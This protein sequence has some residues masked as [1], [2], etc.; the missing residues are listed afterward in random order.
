MSKHCNCKT[1][2]LCITVK[3]EALKITGPKDY[4]LFGRSVTKSRVLE[5]FQRFSS[6]SSKSLSTK[7]V[8]SKKKVAYMSDLKT[9]LGQTDMIRVRK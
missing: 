8:T 1:V 7:R 9:L 2:P 6:V 5:I 3:L 4:H